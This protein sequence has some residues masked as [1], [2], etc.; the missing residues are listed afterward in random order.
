MTEKEL[1]RL[2]FARES[3]TAKLELIIGENVYEH[4]YSEICLPG[5]GYARDEEGKLVFIQHAGGVKI[6]DNVDIRAFVTI[7]R[8]T[9][10]GEF[11]EIGEGTKIDH[12]THIAHNVKIGKHNTFANGCVIEGSCEVGDYNIFGTNVIMQ[13]KTKLGNNCTIGSG[14]VITRDIPDNAIVMGVPARVIRFKIQ[15]L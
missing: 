7:D 1:L 3:K 13:R 11:T 5:F 8:A 14:S 6:G 12:H 2:E 4:Q 15:D 9:I 10:K